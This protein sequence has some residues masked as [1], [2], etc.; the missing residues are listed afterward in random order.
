[1]MNF[2][3]LSSKSPSPETPDK[4]WFAE[5]Q[6][7]LL[8]KSCN[9]P[10]VVTGGIDVTIQGVPD[11]STLNFVPGI[12]VGVA[13]VRFLRALLPEGPAEFLRLGKVFDSKK[14][15]SPDVVTFMG[16]KTVVIR[17]GPQSGFRVCPEC[18]RISYSP[19]GKRYVLKRDVGDSSV[20]DAWFGT[21]VVSDLVAQRLSSGKWK[22]LVVQKLEVRDEPVDGLNVPG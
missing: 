2:Y 3:Q 21:L 20:L 1:M 15:E 16:H 11:R 18:R 14:R 19:I 4:A 7:T 13:E 22:N 5:A 9:A 8:C 12:C 17:G 10:R 6:K